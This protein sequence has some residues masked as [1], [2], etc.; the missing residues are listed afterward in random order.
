M[1]GL[2]MAPGRERRG[3]QRGSDADEPVGGLELGG[4]DAGGAVR[5]RPTRPS[6]PRAAGRPTGRA[7]PRRGPGRR[8][9]PGTPA[10]PAPVAPALGWLPGSMSHSMKNGSCGSACRPLTPSCFQSSSMPSGRCRLP[11]TASRPRRASCGAMSSTATTQPSQPPPSC[12][13]GAHGLSER[14]LV[15]G[16]VVEDL[17]DLEVGARRS[18]GGS[19]CGCRSGGG[20]RRWR[21]PRR[22]APR[23]VAVV[24]ASPPGPAAKTMWSRRMV[25]SHPTRDRRRTPGVGSARRQVERRRRGRV[26][27]ERR[28]R[29][30]V[31]LA[32]RRQHVVRRLPHQRDQLGGVGEVDRLGADVGLGV[33]RAVPVEV[34]AAG[35]PA[36]AV[37][38][39]DGDLEVRRVVVALDVAER[40]P[41]RQLPAHVRLGLDEVHVLVAAPGACSAQP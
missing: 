32:R 34:V 25:D 15:G 19:R 7:T 12:G 5:A 14:G 36:A 16:R 29:A 27:R 28:P 2:G 40:T 4:D 8:R 38:L 33:A 17:D 20:R 37:V 1:F 39:A 23:G 35:T 10:R 31:R 6:R 41:D 13:A 22:A 9:S 11:L 26:Q 30:Q 3:H 24:P 21:T 18:A